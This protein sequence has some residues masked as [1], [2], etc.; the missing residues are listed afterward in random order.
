MPDAIDFI[1]EDH[2]KILGLFEQFQQAD[3]DPDRQGQL[4]DQILEALTRH[5]YIENECLYPEIRSRVPST[6][7][8]VLESFE[9]HH[10]A[11]VLGFELAMMNPSDEHYRAK[12]TVL[13]ET[14]INHIEEEEN[15]LF[16][17][18]RDVL[19]AEQLEEIGDRLVELMEEAPRKP[20][21][22]RALKKAIQ[23]LRA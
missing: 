6:D 12:T 19:T 2:R 21:E 10:V 14:I 4:V 9:E 22:P 3:G 1:M 20:T 11:D 8:A 15:E 16:P 7:E 23:A 13:M 17:K 18:V 5:T